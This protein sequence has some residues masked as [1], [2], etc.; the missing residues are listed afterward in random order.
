LKHFFILFLL[1]FSLPNFPEGFVAGTQVKTDC[2]YRSIE[3]I[4]QG[5]K[6]CVY[7]HKKKAQ[8]FC[9]VEE[10]YR[11]RVSKFVRLFLDDTTLD[12]ASDQKLSIFCKD[13]WICADQIVNNSHLQELCKKEIGLV[14][15]AYVLEP[16]D[17]YIFTLK[18]YHTFYVTHANI[19]AHNFDLSFVSAVP[20]VTEVMPLVASGA[21]TAASTCN[22]IIVIGACAVV[23]GYCLYQRIA[24]KQKHKEKLK[25]SQRKLAL[26]RQQMLAQEQS[27]GT[28]GGGPQKNP[29]NNKK[30]KNKKKPPRE[31][32]QK[33]YELLNDDTKFI[34][35]SI[36]DRA[37]LIRNEENI[38]R[39]K[40]YI[41]RE[42]EKLK[43]TYTDESVDFDSHGQDVYKRRSNTY[44][45]YDID[46]H[47]GGFWKMYTRRTKFRIGTFNLDL[48]ICVGV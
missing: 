16:I 45:T 23:G 48:S 42:A 2:G 33:D 39:R 38:S 6:V 26:E 7:D 28:F 36:E 20:C 25:Q 29:K 43:Y 5:M 31:Y 32:T 1:F 24:A 10:V 9:K 17:V 41:R 11:S 46:D 13:D 19:I 18:K 22:P 30:N 15:A 27:N 8:R 35:L 21:C 47:K 37:W 44:I 40:H 34:D 14:H 3:S 4:A 12:V